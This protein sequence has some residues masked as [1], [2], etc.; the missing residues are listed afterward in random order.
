M[1]T[2]VDHYSTLTANTF[3]TV[4]IELDWSLSLSDKPFI[5]HVQHFQERHVRLY[6]RQIIVD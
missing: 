2:T 3:P 4:V 1:G 6:I 5:Q